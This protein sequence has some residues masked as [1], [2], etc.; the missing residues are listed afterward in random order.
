M[1]LFKKNFIKIALI[2]T[3]IVINIQTK[4]MNVIHLFEVKCSTSTAFNHS[5]TSG[6]IMCNKLT[7]KHPEIINSNYVTLKKCKYLL[8]EYDCN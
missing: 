5:S 7:I 8:H 2:L 3:F 4:Y 6:L 1:T